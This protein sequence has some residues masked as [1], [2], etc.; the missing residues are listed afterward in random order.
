[1]H[2]LPDPVVSPHRPQ[3]QWWPTPALEADWVLDHRDEFD[4]FHLH[5]G[6]D[7]RRPDQL[8]DLTAALRTTG[9][10]F[11]YTVHDLR[12]PHHDT[13]DLHDEQLDVLVPA[14]DELVTL[15]HGAAREIERRW[16]RAARVLP[17]PH[18]VEEPTQ[19]RLR[20]EHDGFV[21]ASVAWCGTSATGYGNRRHP[22]LS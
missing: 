18:V 16:G 9:K 8:A 17:H 5:F 15:T 11:L 21:V 12:N 10:P 4:L 14:A 19:S 13:R 2:R 22:S 1:M 7:A 6:F 20:P 3:S